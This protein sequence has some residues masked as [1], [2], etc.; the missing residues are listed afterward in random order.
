MAYTLPKQIL[1]RT[2]YLSK[3]YCLI[4]HAFLQD[5][6]LLKPGSLH[7]GCSEVARD[8]KVVVAQPFPFIT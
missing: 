2:Y 8:D 1:M 6:F 4:H 5:L 3:A 7:K